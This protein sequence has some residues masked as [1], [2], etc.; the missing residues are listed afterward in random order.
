MG[1]LPIAPD[2]LTT[3][4]L[5][6]EEIVVVAAPGHPLARLSQPI[7]TAQLAEHTQLVL[8]D[9]SRLSDGRQFGVTSARIWH[10][11][12]L[13]AKL[14]F[15]RAGLGYGGMPKTMIAADLRAGDLVQLHVAEAASPF[16][17]P[18]LA[19]YRLDAPPGPAGRWL[20]DRLKAMPSPSSR[21]ANV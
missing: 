7:T 2:E 17:M 14:A 8:T 5:S 20:I 13:G 4:P 3:E 18:M 21:P 15:L 12:D 9:R 1:S 6:R 19:V 16:L 11:A 10:L